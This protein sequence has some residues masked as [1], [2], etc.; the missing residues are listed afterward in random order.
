MWNLNKWSSQEQKENR[1]MGEN[2]RGN[3]ETWDRGPTFTHT[4][5]SRDQIAA[6]YCKLEFCLENSSKLSS[7]HTYLYREKD[8]YEVM[9]GIWLNIW[10]TIIT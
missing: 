4:V 6:D 5:S 8:N 9:A 10:H 3:W 7:P 1:D 2:G